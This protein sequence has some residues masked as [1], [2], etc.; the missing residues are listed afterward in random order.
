MDKLDIQFTDQAL[1][2]LDAIPIRFARQI[3]RKIQRLENGPQGDIKRLTEFDYDYRLRSGNHRVLFDRI[4]N[5]IVIHR[6][7]DRKS[8]YD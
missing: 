5:K 8:A 4:G 2:D 3:I 7:L 1:T 6:I